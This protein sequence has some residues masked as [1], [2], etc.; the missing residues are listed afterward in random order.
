MFQN[1]KL[2]GIFGHKM[3]EIKRGLKQ[4]RNEEV[5]NIYALEILLE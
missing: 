3:E 2:I 1:R 5:H 4:L